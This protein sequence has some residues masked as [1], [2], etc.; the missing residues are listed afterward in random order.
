MKTLLA[1]SIGVMILVSAAAAVIPDI[2]YLN[3]VDD[4]GDDSV[5][6]ESPWLYLDLSDLG[7]LETGIDYEVSIMPIIE[8]EQCT[9]PQI[10]SEYNIPVQPV[11]CNPP[12][13][14]VLP[15]AY[16]TPT[17]PVLPGLYAYPDTS[18]WNIPT[19]DISIW[20]IPTWE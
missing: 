15:G 20:N 9:L 5:G 14:S 4:N 11:V 10:C 8:R 17:S 3:A 2:E 13:Q 18:T 12:D 19:W 16:P 7:E 1:F 6:I